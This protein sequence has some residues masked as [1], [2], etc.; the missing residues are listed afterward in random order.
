LDCDPKDRRT[1]INVSPVSLLL[2]RLKT[3]RLDDYGSL[4]SIEVTITISRVNFI[5]DFAQFGP[6]WCCTVEQLLPRSP[7]RS[8]LKYQ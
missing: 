2:A 4:Q 6:A 3:R 1:V 5:P 7:L 8:V